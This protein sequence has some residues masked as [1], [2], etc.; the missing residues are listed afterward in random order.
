MQVYTCT[1]FRG[2]FPASTAAIV[3]AHTRK[4]AVTI[5]N[6][7]LKAH[8]LRPDVAVD[9]L[10]LVDTTRPGAAILCDGEY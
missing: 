7:R 4:Q 3:A 9:D 10:Q 1:T 5:L 2:F 6:A 8:G